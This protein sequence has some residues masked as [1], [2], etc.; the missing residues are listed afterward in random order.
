MAKNTRTKGQRERDEILITQMYLEGHRLRDIANQIGVT[1]QT[2][3]TILQRL[4][5]EW[6]SQA[7]K[8]IDQLKVIELERINKLE[9]RA[10]KALEDSDGE[11]EKHSEKM[12]INGFETAVTRENIVAD[13]RYMKIILD[14]IKTRCQILGID[15]EEKEKESQFDP[16]K[17]TI[18][19]VMPTM[20]NE[21]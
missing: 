3:Q 2:I 21:G 9:L 18:N 5:K 4:I 10:W 11:I 20:T 13:P 14:C 6:Q 19:V 8:N 17:I 15:T 12:T 7:I 16:S 1:Y